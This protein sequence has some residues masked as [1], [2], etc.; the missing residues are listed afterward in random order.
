ML[1]L[2][3]EGNYGAATAALEKR[4]LA[5]VAGHD[6]DDEPLD[7]EEV[8]SQVLD[9]TRLAE[10]KWRYRV[11]EVGGSPYDESLG[12]LR[13]AKRL[14][15]KHASHSG[16]T[17]VAS[18]A[19]RPPPKLAGWEVIMKP[20]FRTQWARE[21]AEV[22]QGLGVTYLIYTA[23]RDEDEQIEALLQ[24]ALELRVTGAMRMSEAETRNSLGLL[25]QKQKRYDDARAFYARSLEIRE[26]LDEVD[27]AADRSFAMHKETDVAKARDQVIAQSL[28]SLGNLAIEQAEGEKERGQHE[29]A[30]R[31]YSEARVHME[32]AQ[33]AYT[34]GFHA[35]HPKV[36]WATEGLAKVLI[37]EGEME[38][39]LQMFESAVS[40]RRSLQTKD[41]EKEFFNEHLRELEGSFK[42]HQQL[43]VVRQQEHDGDYGAVAADLERWAASHT[44]GA[45][46]QGALSDETLR[47]QVLKMTR[48]AETKWRYGTPRRAAPPRVPP[49]PHDGPLARRAHTVLRAGTASSTWGARRTTSRSPCWGRPSGCS[50]RTRG[51]HRAPTSPSTSVRSGRARLPRC[52]RGSA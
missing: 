48:L 15:E 36:A 35:T 4:A 22:Q 7:E 3:H 29:A 33:Q 28:V 20:D 12:Y 49:T 2:E 14:L 40:I 50:R 31:F 37:N 41:T 47:T 21:I 30:K 27:I 39:A 46:G 17:C 9:L 18:K 19:V 11:V 13:S 10:M 52:S 32:S 6:G 26:A 42:R 38:R 44:F 45:D 51:W 5:V 34:R 8:S 23:G 25:R 1:Q 24:E 43:Q 16:G